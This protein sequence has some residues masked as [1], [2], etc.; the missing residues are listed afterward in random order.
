[1]VCGAGVSGGAGLAAEVPY[2]WIPPPRG[3]WP[4]QLH[5]VGG[6]VV[7]LGGGAGAPGQ[8]RVGG[9]AGQQQGEAWLGF[10]Q[11]P[12]QEDAVAGL[13]PLPRGGVPLPGGRPAPLLVA[14]DAVVPRVAPGRLLP[15]LPQR[16]WLRSLGCQVRK[17][18]IL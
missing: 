5:G 12:W 1:M 4:P 10:V 2:G 16:P 9:V 8:L 15:R 6:E 3:C 13:V 17:G 7:V 14:P 11:G 18:R